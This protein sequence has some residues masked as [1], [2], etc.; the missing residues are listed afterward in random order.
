MEAAVALR[1]TSGLGGKGG[2]GGDLAASLVFVVARLSHPKGV[3]R[4]EGAVVSFGGWGDGD[5]AFVGL[6]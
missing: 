2:R 5:L 4:F 1:S 6:V 3:F